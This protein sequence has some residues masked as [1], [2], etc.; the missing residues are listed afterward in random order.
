M[1]RETVPSINHT[2][3]EII[4]TQVILCSTFV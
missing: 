4:L 2:A 1:V 3:S